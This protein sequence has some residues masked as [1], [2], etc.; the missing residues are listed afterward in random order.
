M[1]Q[2]CSLCH[3]PRVA[4]RKEC[5]SALPQ[6]RL[7][8]PHYPHRGGRPGGPQAALKRLERTRQAR[9]VQP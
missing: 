5:P 4:G 3:E 7:L 6:N 2:R 9:E 1:T 8:C